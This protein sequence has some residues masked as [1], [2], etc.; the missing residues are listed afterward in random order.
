[1]AL[2]VDCRPATLKTQFLRARAQGQKIFL[3]VVGWQWQSQPGPWLIGRVALG[4]TFDELRNLAFRQRAEEGVDW[5]AV[6]EGEHR[7]DRLDVELH[8]NRGVLVD[9]HLDELH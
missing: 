8:R 4:E 1:M 7:R 5:L 2:V 3:R 6:D 9:V